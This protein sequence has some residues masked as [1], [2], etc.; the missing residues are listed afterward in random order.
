MRVATGKVVEGPCPEE[1]SVVT[2]LA[3]EH[4]ETFELSEEEGE[5]ILASG[6]VQRG[7]VDRGLA[8]HTIAYDIASDKERAASITTR[9]AISRSWPLLPG[10]DVRHGQT[11]EMPVV[12]GR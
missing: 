6:A 1:G 2:V 11:V 8:D 5:L 7:G 9:R 10:V 4:T 3:R 12:A